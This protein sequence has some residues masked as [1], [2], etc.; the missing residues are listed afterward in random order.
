MSLE[1]DA[2]KQGGV[3]A[4]GSDI[5]VTFCLTGQVGSADFPVWMA[6]HAHKLGVGFTITEQT[7]RVMTVTSTGAAD[8]V[9]AF[10]LACSLGPRSVYVEA[11][12]FPDAPAASPLV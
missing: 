4:A 2:I 6:R 7:A 8:M 10:A 9:E 1:N 11:L 3:M 5:N 12:C